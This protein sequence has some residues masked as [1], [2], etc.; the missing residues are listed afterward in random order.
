MVSGDLRWSL[1]VTA[2]PV[3]HQLVM[4]FSDRT[5]IGYQSA[6]SFAIVDGQSYTKK[7]FVVVLY[8]FGYG[9]FM[10]QIVAY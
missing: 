2:L 9:N 8:V 5:E 6:N 3:G 1:S 4:I 10:S 7:C